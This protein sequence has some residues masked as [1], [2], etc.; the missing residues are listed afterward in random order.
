[1]RASELPPSKNTK[2]KTSFPKYFAFTYT[3][4]GK[5]HKAINF[6][7]SLDIAACTVTDFQYWSL[8]PILENGWALLGELNK[9][10]PVSE[11]RFTD[12]VVESNGLFIGFM[13]GV[14]G[15][16]VS[17]TAYDTGSGRTEVYSCTIGAD[18]NSAFYFPG[19]TC[20][21]YY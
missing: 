11:T 17:I 3:L 13:T 15:E 8:A 5:V 4:D 6:T 2:P 21:D 19:G 16:L 7:G 18:G 14:P 12:I 10:I 1:M 9:I 20:V